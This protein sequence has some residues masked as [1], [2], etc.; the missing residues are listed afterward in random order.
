MLTDRLLVPRQ[1]QIQDLQWRLH[2]VKIRI[3]PYEWNRRINQ[4]WRLPRHGKWQV[5]SVTDLRWLVCL[6]QCSTSPLQFYWRHLNSSDFTHHRWILLPSNSCSL[7]TRYDYWPTDLLHRL[8]NERCLRQTHWCRHHRH[9]PHRPPCHEHHVV[10][11]AHPRLS[12]RLRLTIYVKWS[13]K[14][15]ESP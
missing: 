10:Y 14:I 5:Q 15:K 11:Q 3:D 4:H 2:E 7:R 6:Q 13:M 12:I 1:S 8:H 9:I